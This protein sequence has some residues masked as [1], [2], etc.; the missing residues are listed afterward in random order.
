[1]KSRKISFDWD[2]T[3]VMSYMVDSSYPSKDTGLP[4]YQFQEY[5]EELIRKIKEYHAAGDEL[6]IVT[7]RKRSLEEY[8][9][10]E[11]VA[12]HIEMLK[13]SHIFP[14][15]R[16]H[17]TE[18]ALKAKTLR[19]LGIVLHHDD[20]MEEII[21]CKRYGIDTFNSLSGYKDSDIVTKGIITDLYGSIL[22]LKRTDDGEK[23]DI[24]GGHIKEIEQNRD[25][26][27]ISDG[28]EREVAEETGLIIPPSRLIRQY[29]HTWKG[30]SIDMYIL[31]TDYATEEPSIDLS[32]QELQEN[33]EFKWVQE[34]DLVLYTSNMTEVAFRA[35]QFFR[36][37]IGN[38]MIM[39]GEYLPSQSRTWAKMKKRLVGLGNNKNTGGGKGH[40]RPKMKKSKASPPDFS[41]LEDKERKKKE[42]KSKL[43][44]MM[45]ETDSLGL[46]S[47]IEGSLKKMMDSLSGISELKSQKETTKEEKYLQHADTLE[48]F[49]K[50]SN[51]Y[52]LEQ[53]SI[54]GSGYGYYY[55]MSDKKIILV[56]RSGEY[57][58]I[59]VVP[60]RKGRLRVYSHYKHNTGIVLLIPEGEIETI[61]W[62]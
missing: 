19:Q 43:S 47:S 15:A 20:S 39:E 54:K 14:P 22:L 61:G 40:T 44:K 41:V 37:N 2:N 59:S 31:W 50:D 62:N 18:G 7:S 5:N 55:S 16:V 1:V 45:K 9:P 3:I 11:S 26:K 53:V 51:G 8:Y 23:W 35:I 33:S 29:V 28:Y 48:K 42:L 30:K 38:P 12:Y 21:E 10:E 6:Y 34:E 60:D 49:I 24:P 17:Y 27:G 32:I 4:I 25:K 46:N 58:L 57:Y 56:P 13:L 52:A 36:E